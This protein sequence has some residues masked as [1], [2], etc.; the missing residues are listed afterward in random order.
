VIGVHLLL[1]GFGCDSERL[2]DA[3]SGARAL[4]AAALAAHMTPLS[5]PSVHKFP[6]G[7][8]TALLALAE[9]HLSI[10]TYPEKNLFCADLF[11]CGPKAD[12]E[13]AVEVLRAALAPARLEVQRI[14]RGGS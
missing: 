14:E 3:E 8:Y 1:D 6:G 11:T 2:T 7:G 13:A 5:V 9:S 12:P 4:T 10:H